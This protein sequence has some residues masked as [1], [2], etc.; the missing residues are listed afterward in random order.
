MAE[1]QTDFTVG[2]IPRH[3]LIFSWPM[4]LGNLLQTMYNTVDSIWVGRFLGPDAL[5]AV[6]VGFPIIFALVSLVMGIA[7]A[8]TVMV[9]QYFGAKQEEMV[10]KTIQNSLVLLVVGGILVSVLGVIFHRP[11]LELINTPKE[12]M[13]DASTYL[14]IFLSGLL[15]MFLYNVLGAILR[16]LGD[17]KTPLVYLA[18]A[19]VLNIILDP[20]L[21]FGLGP[22]PRLGVAGAALAT[23]ISQAV[24]AWLGMKYL[25]EKGLLGNW[26]GFRLDWQI[27]SKTFKIGIPAGVQQTV[28]S[29]G[30]LVVNSLINSFGKVVVAAFAI[31]VRLEGFA[32]MPIMSL[33]LATSAVAGQNLGAGKMERAQKSLYWSVILVVAIAAS[34]GILLFIAPDLW[35]SVFTKDKAVMAIGR[36]YIRILAFSYIPFGVMFVINGLLRG[37]GDTMATMLTSIISLWFIRVPLAYYLARTMGLGS[38]GVWL[39]MAI[40]PLFGLLLSYLYYR[41]GRWKRAVVTGKINLEEA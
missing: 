9:A 35:L 32:F 6:S 23:V 19:T 33:S 1:K 40:G 24:S 20:I 14:V 26:Q 28:V 11:L 5:G 39:S 21:I 36:E 22:I 4:F 8:T 10:Q 18:Y 27:I 2:S 15:F 7:M 31:G 25:Q 34:V 13:Q 38:R 3:L 41:T 29:V 37:A 17:S 16:G 12:L 30:Q